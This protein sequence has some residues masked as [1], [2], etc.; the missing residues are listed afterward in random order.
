MA[1]DKFDLN[2]G[3]RG[4][5][6]VDLARA[7]A[8]LEAA[9]RRYD[10]AVG[11]TLDGIWDWDI[12]TNAE[13]FA[14]RWCE[15][16]GYAPDDPTLPHTYESWA[17]RIHPEDRARVEQAVADHLTQGLPYDVTYRHLHASGAYRWQTSRG[18]ALR[19]ADGKPVRMVGAIRD[20]TELK[21]AEEARIELERKL[22]IEERE[23]RIAA[24]RALE[25]ERE[26]AESLA[27]LNATL[28]A[29]VAERTFDL[30]RSTDQLQR[31]NAELRQFAHAASHDLRSPLRAIDTLT[32][33]LENDLN[34]VLKGE[35]REQMRLLRSR[36][37]RMD[38]L[39]ADLL[40]YSRA[41][42]QSHDTEEV[43]ARDLI[44]EVIGLSHVPQE[45]EVEVSSDL[46][47]FTTVKLPLQRVLLNLVGN[48]IKHH[49]RPQGCVRISARDAGTAVEFL[50]VDDGPGIAPEF[51]AKVFQ[52]FQTLKPRDSLEGSGM[53]LALVAKLVQAVGGT[54]G[55]ESSG[56]GTTFRLSWPK[57]IKLC[58]AR[59]S[60]HGR[61][62]EPSPSRDVGE[63]IPVSRNEATSALPFHVLLVDDDDVDAMAV[64]RALTANGSGHRL[65]TARDGLE[66]LA[67]LRGEGAPQVPRP[68][69]IVLDL[70][71]PRM[72]GVEF[73][74]ELRADPIHGRAIVFVLTT[75]DAESDKAA[76]Y[77]AGVAGYVVK[78]RAGRDLD[79]LVALLAAYR[80]AVELP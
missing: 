17:S 8:E 30:E 53:G 45:F 68:Y 41:E 75:S 38:L 12:L 50:V 10:L 65:F 67:M 47:P 78:A 37:R 77:D 63:R 35:T 27:M 13:Y 29:R 24:A 52:M 56:R 48:A 44:S 79:R 40:A 33:W 69:L 76:A 36:V 26:R 3:E 70:N 42:A 7:N 39:L 58:E 6:N 11:A 32:E 31:A 18:Q 2:E 61:A 73:L 46:G 66:A 22:Q 72:N 49:D 19:D 51:H 59:E 1:S 14:P 64:R 23:K 4:Q 60:T 16:L 34:D 20:V 21:Q 28:E 54:I 80:M 55:L 57:Q 71:M 15:I 74:R 9:T 62:N 25:L 5:L 43:D